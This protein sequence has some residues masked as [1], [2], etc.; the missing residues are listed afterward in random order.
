LPHVPHRRSRHG[1]RPVR[2]LR[3][4]P[5]APLSRSLPRLVARPGI[6]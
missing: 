2:D 6:A 3:L 5:P 4:H 1:R